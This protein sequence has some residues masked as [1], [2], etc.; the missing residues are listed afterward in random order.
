MPS[1]LDKLG[2]APAGS[3]HVLEG[4]KAAKMRAKTMYVPSPEDV[5]KAVTAIPEGQ[6]RSFLELRR[7]LA[8]VGQA[9]IACP[10]ATTK[11]WKWLAQAEDELDG[12]ND[13]FA[14]PWWRVL[15][16]G[17]PYPKLPGGTERQA[18]LLQAEGV[19]I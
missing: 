9:E 15:K 2:Q 12:Q 11:Y 3:F 16:D 7:E 8:Q 18:A 5:A 13:L 14:V 17:K 6:T 10:S 4:A 1:F 19:Q